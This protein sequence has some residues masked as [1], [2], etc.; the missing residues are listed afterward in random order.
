MAASA[1]WLKPTLA[2]E[3][4]TLRPVT[5]DD[6]EAMWEMINDPEGNEL[7]VS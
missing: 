3:L 1:R 5:I 7:C 2:G 4:V 6:A